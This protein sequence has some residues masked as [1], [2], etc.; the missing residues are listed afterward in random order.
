MVD[1]SYRLLGIMWE[2]SRR[3]HTEQSDFKSLAGY[4]QN[5]TRLVYDDEE[6]HRK[7]LLLHLLFSFR[8]PLGLRRFITLSN[9]IISNIIK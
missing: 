5:D 3:I 4:D 9:L 2:D 1:R 7:V 6:S 8:P